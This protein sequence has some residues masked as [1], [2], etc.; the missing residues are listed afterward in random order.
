MIYILIFQNIILNYFIYQYMQENYEVF[1]N[2]KVIFSAILWGGGRIIR[3]EINL[4]HGIG[5]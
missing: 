5:V 3:Y 1:F 4:P 2:P